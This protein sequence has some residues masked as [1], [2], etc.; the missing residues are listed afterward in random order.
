M[1]GKIEVSLVS[2]L[3][4]IGII[5]AI[6]LGVVNYLTLREYTLVERYKSGRY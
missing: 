5:A 6:V 2:A 4:I 3:V 1:V